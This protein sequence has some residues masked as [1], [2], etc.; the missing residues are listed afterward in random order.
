MSKFRFGDGLPHDAKGAMYDNF[1]GGNLGGWDKGEFTNTINVHQRAFGPEYT[2]QM[3]FKMFGVTDSTRV[4]SYA[5][6]QII[7][8]LAED[9]AAGLP[10]NIKRSPLY[11]GKANS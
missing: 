2:N 6:G 9:M 5:Y 7:A 11:A 3:L 8:A 1:R 4:P 10:H